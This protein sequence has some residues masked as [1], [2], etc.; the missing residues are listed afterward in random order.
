MFHNLYISNWT[1]T[2]RKN[3]KAQQIF[4]FASGRLRN[5][6]FNRYCTTYLGNGN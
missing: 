4:N 1:N 6:K 5:N 3:G 2:G